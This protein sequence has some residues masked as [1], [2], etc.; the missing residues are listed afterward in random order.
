[1]AGVRAGQLG[2]HTAVVDRGA[3]GGACLNWG[4]IPSKALIHAART[5]ETIESAG[6]LGI[7]VGKPEIDVPKLI[8]WKDATVGRLTGG[9][10]TLLK[11][12]GV[13]TIVGEATVEAPGRVLVREASGERVLEARAI[14]VAT[15]SSPIELPAL[16]FDGRRII[17][18]KDALSLSA[19]PSRLAVIGGGAIGLELGGAWARLG[20]KVTVIEL[21]PQL[22]PGIDPEIVQVVA[23]GLRR[24]GIEALTGR[25]VTGSMLDGDVVRLEVQDGAGERRTLE[26]DVV[27]V[28]VGMRPNTAGLGL[29][30]AGVKLDGKGFVPV[31]ARL[32]TNVPEILAIGDITGPPLLAHRASAQGEVAVEALAGRDVSYDPSV[33]PGAVFVEPEVGTVG[34]SEAQAAERGLAIKVGKFPFAALGRTVVEGATDGFVKVVADAGSGRVLGIH[35]VGAEASDLLGEAAVIVRAGLTAEEVGRTI[36]A[37]PTRPEALME[38]AKAAGEGAIHVPGKAGKS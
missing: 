7:R 29:E 13:E 1:V 9:I 5:V 28:A 30:R 21:L 31:D 4:C 27:L 18:A 11:S 17:A 32:R 2:L 24:R 19:A 14:V 10:R 20:S 26:A 36:H 35:I 8:A 33:V 38:A 12:H 15:G 3:W 25:K 23:R 6:K 34:L 37:H 22:L 16:P